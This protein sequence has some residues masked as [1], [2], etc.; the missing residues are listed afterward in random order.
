MEPVIL[1]NRILIQALINYR[2]SFRP[3]QSTD[4]I[5]LVHPDPDLKLFICVF[6]FPYLFICK[7]FIR[8]FFTYDFILMTFNLFLYIKKVLN[9]IL[10]NFLF[11]INTITFF[12]WESIEHSLIYCKIFFFKSWM[13]LISCASIYKYFLHSRF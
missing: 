3:F 12:P 4:R 8:L 1:R 11:S 9:W 2:F 5:Q 7:T 10:W 13:F 6:S